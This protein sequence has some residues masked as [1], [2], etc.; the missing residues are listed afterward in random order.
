MADDSASLIIP[1]YD[2]TTPNVLEE[3]KAQTLCWQEAVVVT[4]ASPAARARN[5]GAGGVHGKYLIFLDDD[6]KFDASDFLKD[7]LEALKSSG[8]RDAVSLTWYLSPKANWLQRVI[9]G[10]PLYTFD[11]AK[12]KAE[13][14]WKECGTA[15]F[16]IRSDWF[17]AL[18]GF[19]E[20]LVSGED[21]ELAYRIVQAGGRIYT[22]PQRRIAHDPPRTLKGVIKKSFWYERGNA[23]VARKHPKA[24]YRVH[25]GNSSKALVYLVS[26]TV[27]VIPLMFFKVNYRQRWPKLSFRPIQTIM[28]YLGAWAYVGEWLFPSK[29]K[30][31]DNP[32][33]LIH[34]FKERSVL[35]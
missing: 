29:A 6:V 7:V 17:A 33:S 14:S 15:C 5:L 24:G 21:C 12:P 25:L 32:N 27:F 34:V 3:L 8:P 22:L 9:F 30:A 4:K 1:S 2:N 31:H 18:Q 13:M 28:S 19:D 20:E 11:R 16:A 23:Q 35:K 26:R 10:E